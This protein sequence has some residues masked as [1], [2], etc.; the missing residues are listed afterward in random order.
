[1][2]GNRF[3]RTFGALLRQAAGDALGTAVELFPIRRMYPDGQ[4]DI[5]GPDAE[6]TPTGQVTDNTEFALALARSLVSRS[7]YDAGDGTA[8]CVVWERSDPFDIGGTPQTFHGLDAPGARLVA[9]N[10]EARISVSS[11]TNCLPGKASRC[12]STRRNMRYPVLESR[13]RA[14]IHE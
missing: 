5:E 4:R 12:P 11:E 14:V 1:M 6:L 7:A 2:N 8:R 9:D 10:L 13:K 3:N